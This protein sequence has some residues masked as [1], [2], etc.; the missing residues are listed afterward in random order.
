VLAALAVV[1]AGGRVG[2]RRAW[3]AWG[4]LA[5]VFAVDVALLALT[6]LREV[7]PSAGDDPRY[8]ADLALVAA[9]CGAFA[10]LPPGEVTPSGGKRERPIALAL[11]VLLLASSAFGF[12]RLAPAL[13]FEHSGQYVGNVRAAVGEDPDLVFYDTFVPSDVVHEWFGADSRASRVVGLLPGT[14][15]DQPTSRM[16]LLDATGT[17]HR[18]TGVD[19]VSRGV[20][21]PVPNCG[22]AIG[23]TPVRVSLDKPVLGRHLLKLDYYTSDGGEGLVD[24]TPVWFQAGLHSLYLPVDGLFDSVA[25]RLSSPGAPVCVA[26]AEVGKPIAQ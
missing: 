19:P 4:L 3:G 12:S 20:P 15:F 6:R 11:C 24:R 21:G 7:G 26:K 8:V 14:R 18:I 22:Y 1:L 17:P 2:G 25:V 23:E 10:F 16:H 9:L 13:R 5:A